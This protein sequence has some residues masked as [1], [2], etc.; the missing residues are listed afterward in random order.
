MKGMPPGTSRR[1]N[2]TT[3]LRQL[4]STPPSHP[5]CLAIGALASLEI[6]KTN[7]S[8]TNTTGKLLQQVAGGLV[9]VGDYAL[10]P[11]TEEDGDGG[12]ADQGNA[13]AGRNF[14]HGRI[15]IASRLAHVHHDDHAQIVISSD[16]A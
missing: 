7:P 6:Q 2:R 16:G 3:G 12:G 9:D 8:Q 14:R 1:K 5:N 4:A 10:R 15:N 13:E 11:D